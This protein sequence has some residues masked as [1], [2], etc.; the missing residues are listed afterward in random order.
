MDGPQNWQGTH[1]CRRLNNGFPDDHILSPRTCHCY[2]KENGILWIK[3]RILGW[4]PSQAPEVAMHPYIQGRQKEIGRRA[5][6]NVTTEENILLRSLKRA[7]RTIVNG[8]RGGA[9][10]KRAW[11]SC[12][13]PG[14][15]SQHSHGS[16][17]S[18]DSCFGES[19]AFFYS[20]LHR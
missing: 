18:P 5:G 1:H 11:G 12:K 3:L 2:H 7:K 13:G 15:Y 14:F 4:R 19:N 9:K 16:S 8:W 20:S 17:W 10:E 6:S